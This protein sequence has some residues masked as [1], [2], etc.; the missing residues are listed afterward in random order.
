MYGI[1]EEGAIYICRTQH[2]IYFLNRLYLQP[3]NKNESHDTNINTNC[4]DYTVTNNLREN[5]ALKL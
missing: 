2:F 1:K 4:S 5:I 3:L